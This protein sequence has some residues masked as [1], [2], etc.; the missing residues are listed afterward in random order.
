MTAVCQQKAASLE[1]ASSLQCINCDYFRVVTSIL[2]DRLEVLD[3]IPR[4]VTVQG[5]T[6][7]SVHS[8]VQS[9]RRSRLQP[10]GIGEMWATF[11]EAQQLEHCLTLQYVQSSGL[12][13]RVVLLR[14]FMNWEERSAFV[15]KMLFPVLLLNHSS[16]TSTHNAPTANSGKGLLCSSNS[17]EDT[18][19]KHTEKLLSCQHILCNMHKHQHNK[20]NIFSKIKQA[21]KHSNV[22]EIHTRRLGNPRAPEYFLP[23]LLHQERLFQCQLFHKC[24]EELSSLRHPRGH[25]FTRE[26]FKSSYRKRTLKRREENSKCHGSFTR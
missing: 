13:L 19:R 15:T 23:A 9:S 11:P 26:T 21:K 4:A 18:P 7:P 2:D 10:Q 12:Y 14:N 1:S 6:S 3:T 5:M 22:A 16:W 24:F 20:I 25:V 8:D 17:S